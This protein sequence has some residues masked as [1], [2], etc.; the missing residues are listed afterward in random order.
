M[1]TKLAKIVLSIVVGMLGLVLVMVV[2]AGAGPAVAMEDVEQDGGSALVAGPPHVVEV[3]A[4]PTEIRADGD[5]NSTITGTVKD[6]DG[7]GVP[8]AFIAFTTT[9]GTI[10][11]YCYVEAEDASVNKSPGDWTIEGYPGASG[12]QYARTCGTTHPNANLSWTF[13]ATAI[14]ML[15]VKD[16]DG[17][18][19]EVQIDGSMAIT[20]DMYAGTK[21]AAERVITAGLGSGSH[22]ITVKYLTRSPVGLG[23]CIRVDAFRCGATTD[24]NGQGTATLTSTLL[25][26]GSEDATVT[27]LSGDPSIPYMITGTKLVKMTASFPNSV[28]VTAN[29]NQIA[30]D[31]TSTS[32][33]EATVRDQFGEYVPNCTMVSFIVTDENSAWIT[34]PYE[35]VEGE[36]PEVIKSSSWSTGTNPLYHGGEVIS[37]TTAGATASWNFTGTAVSLMY[38]KLSDAGVATVTVDSG[39]PITI[40]MYTSSPQYQVEHVITHA[41]KSGPHVITVTVAGYTVTGGTDKRV[42]VDAFRSGVSTSGGKATAV[43][44]SGTQAGVVIVEATGVGRPCCETARVVTDR[45]PITLTSGNPYT[46]TITPSNVS[47]TC[48]VTS[49][50]QFTVTDR[51]NNQVGLVVPRT[52]T[53][54]FTSKPSGIFTP[55]SVVV[56]N[57]AGSVIFHGWVS[58]TGTITGTVR[59]YS[60]TDTSNLTVTTASCYTLTINANPTRIYVTDTN[61]SLLTNF[62]YTSTITAEVKDKCGNPVQD[63][64]MVTLTTSLGDLSSKTVTKTT[65]SGRVTA[66]LTSEQLPAGVPTQTAYITVTGA[67]CPV[68]GTTSVTFGR[69]VYTLTVTANP[70]KI[71]VSG[72]TSTLTADVDD[73]F[74]DPAPNG[75]M[76]GFTITPTIRASVPYE[77]V[78]AENGAKVTAPGWSVATAGGVTYIHTDTVGAWASWN[79]TGTAVSFVYHQDPT[80]GAVTVTINNPAYTRTID[81]SGPDAWIERVITTGLSFAS[82]KVTVTVKTAP[83]GS[84]TELDAF[85]SG[86]TTSGGGA[87]A[88][89]TSGT[90]P[91]VA[92]IKAAAIGS[93]V[94]NTGLITITAGDPYTLTITPTDVSITCCVTSTLQFTVTDQYSNVVGTVVPTAVT[95]NFTSTLYGVFT[96][97]TSVVVT[98]GVGSVIFHGYEAGTGIIEGRVAG[99]YPRGTDTSNLTVS[100]GSPALLTVTRAPTTILADGL[101]TAIITATVKDSCENPVCNRIVTFTTDLGS[102]EPP[103]TTTLSITKTTNCNGIA[104]APLRSGCSSR[105]ANVT[106]TVDSLTGTTYV[107]MVGVAWDV[108]LVANP[109]SIQVGGYTSNLT[110]TV[111]DQFGHFVVDGTAVTFTT[112]LGSVGSTTITKTTISGIAKAVLTSSNT[113][114]TA[115]ITA[116]AGSGVDTATGTVTVTFTVG[117][118]YTVTLVAYPMTLTVENSSSLTATVKDLGNNNVVNGTVVTFTTNLGNVGSNWVT[119]TTTSGVVTA[120]LT[121]QVA[122]TASVTATADSKYGTTEVTFQPGLPYTLTLAAYPMILTVGDSSTLTATVKDQYNNNVANGTLVSFTTSWGS[123]GSTTVSKTTTGGIATATLT[124]QLPGT[125]AITATAGSISD[126]ETVV[127][128]VGLPSTVTLEAYPTSIPIAGYTSTLTATVKDKCNNAVSNGTLVTFTTS[129]GRLGSGPVTKTTISGVATAVLTSETTAGTAIVTATS[130][131]KVATTTVKFT[132]LSPYTVTLVAYPTN[133]TVGGTS[134]LTATVQDRYNNNVAN[135]T[136]VTFETSLGSLGSVTITRGTTNGVATATLTSQVPGTATVTATADSVSGTVNVTFKAGLPYTVTLTANPTSILVG[137]FTSTLTV[138]VTDQLNNNVTDGT[139]VTLATSLGSLDGGTVTKTTASGVA[140]ATLT[141]GNT[142]GAAVVTAASDS[143]VATTTVTFRPDVPYTVTLIAYPTSLIVGSTSALT[144]TVKDQYNNNVANGT[145]VTFETSLGS[146]GSVTVTKTTAN[147][148]TTATLTSQIP[149]M[150][151]ITATSDSKVATTTVKFEHGSPY[152]VTLVAYPTSPTA[153]NSSS[154]TATVKD[155]YNNNVADGTV[156][157]FTTSLGDVGSKLVTKVTTSGVATANL[158]SQVAGT[159]LVTATADSKYATAN[160]T[161]NPGPPYTVAVRAYPTSIPIGWFTSTITATVKDLYGNMVANGTEVTFTTDLGSVGSSSVVK[162]TVN[163]VAKAT[164]TSGLIIGTANVSAT[165]DS[166]VGQTQ[167][168]FTVGAPYTVTAE[169]WP[170]TIEVGGNTATITATVTDIGGYAV[171]NGTPVVFTT[172]FGS[173]GSTTVTRTTVSGVAMAT[174]TSGLTSGVAH[175]TATADSKSD[176]AIVKIAAGPP[177]S[178]NVTANPTHIPIGGATS[179]ITAT[180]KDQYGNNVT[181][182]TNVV[183]TTTLGT[184]SPSSNTTIEGVAGTTLISEDDIGTARVTAISGSAIGWVDVVFTIGPPVYVNVV[185]NPTSIGLNGQTSNIQATVKDAGGNNVGDGTEVIFI[186]SLGTLGSNTVTK[187][188]TSGVAIAVLTSGT[189]A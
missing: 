54:D 178:I 46:L 131:S 31:R 13:M 143:K 133:L 159:A 157:T 21:V 24:A 151:T 29:P 69:H 90:Q 85:R 117:P 139:V 30:A 134:M 128:N 171:A 94:T 186:T 158:T 104:T 179:S 88:T 147:G 120:I 150:A 34:L 140:T 9:L 15:Y 83:G 119:K 80:R 66:T 110:A 5:S 65:I 187:T 127:F 6:S 130:D 86:T 7:L 18:V 59:G 33:L 144:A 60:V 35:L 162:T 105:R 168:I 165:S 153:G 118:P 181:N 138:T 126:T 79:F 129:L 145:V 78:E 39:L 166:V 14:S 40:D 2:L 100:A 91:G 62:R 182:G 149:G 17:G 135:G 71:K 82:R 38:P 32:T 8:G 72:Y 107:D 116:T 19:A 36:D 172:D 77:Y 47:I 16:A 132:P 101:A 189:T 43:L 74:G 185:A 89:A 174:L 48:C 183:F 152:T 45:V 49:T 106:V 176:T 27:A 121:S 87:T 3:D 52:L 70:D 64:T 115:T 155:Q 63:G 112:N 99:V 154:L 76:V 93:T 160:V 55:T 81:M 44:T 156:V 109:T 37:S 114:G 23:T 61:T 167:V 142:A 102:F 113:P 56:T 141:S 136:V 75:V 41:L 97:T 169:S 25:S 26:C 1:T 163:G 20:V 68:S 22:I 10:D 51:Y 146:L 96:P 177:S 58:G 123:L 42:Y 11:Q 122:G 188:T 53:V 173:L 4:S 92:T 184:L 108:Q 175:I 12:G 164:L 180:V 73:G 103:P 84:D 111:N 124:S 67:S 125:A 137:G 148:V 98:N 28:T 161:F 170:P 50:L 57:G 95:V